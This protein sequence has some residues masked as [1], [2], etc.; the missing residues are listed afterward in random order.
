[1]NDDATHRFTEI[2]VCFAPPREAPSAET[3]V[4][5]FM[6]PSAEAEADARW[7][8]Q[9]ASGRRLVDEVRARARAEYVGL[10]AR[11]GTTAGRD[12]R[13]V[14][15]A[16]GGPGGYSRWWLLQLTEKDCVWDGDPLYVMILRLMAVQ[17]VVER[18]RIGRIRLVG[19][20]RLFAAALG[21]GGMS[22][23]TAIALLRAA[24]VG[25]AARLALAGELLGL[26]WTERRLP[27]RAASP[28][29][30]LLQGYWD[31][32]VR[33][34]G[35]GGLRD[36]YFTDLPSEL[37]R[38]G[39]SVGWLVSCETRQEPWQHGRRRRDVVAEASAHP[40]I[41]LL[42]KYWRPGDIVR[43]A[44]NLRY[45][46]RT[47]RF[48][49]GRGCRTAC[50]V[51]T[52]N[53][54]A[55]VRD[56]LLRAAWGSTCARLELVATAAARAARELQPRLVLTFMELFLRARAIYAGVSAAGVP[57]AAL[58]AAQHGGYSSDKT[59]GVVDP[60]V[61]MRGAP[62]GCAMPSPDGIFVMGDLSRRIWQA[63]GIAAGRVVPTGGLRYQSAQIR[64]E[65]RAVPKARVSVLLA[66]GMNESAEL[67][68][69]DAAVAACAGLPSVRLLWRNHPI[70]EFSRRPAFRRFQ[71][72]IHVTSG[73]LEE[74]LESADLV[75]FTHAGIA[76]EA[77]LRAIP[78]WQWR[79]AGFNTSPF[80][81]VPVIPSFTS[82]AALRR[83]LEQFVRDPARY[84]PTAE[85][86]RRVLHECFGADPAGASSRMAD[87]IE[88]VVAGEAR[89]LA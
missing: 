71:G 56:L 44:L 61:E 23:G 54:H 26:W 19:A 52:S 68:L 75:L 53:V 30:V 28:R 31:W 81:D 74:D 20:P 32:S 1:M 76:E 73:S 8:A 14:R 77:L 29:D 13:T 2:W 16:L 27:R 3:L 46:W 41:T 24:A 6:L 40:E 79:W 5:S 65:R 89:A 47:T 66:C 78:A 50:R 59:L 88:R 57:R 38:R 55:V 22:R 18:H 84:R 12:G 60:D 21:E 45:A 51:G 43:S 82:V 87:A 7:G 4:L 85:V 9:L 48:V 35:E 58:W 72:A 64:A 70:Y 86:Q 67:E 33:P 17:T 34:D 11:L 42:E 83:E 10:V 15:Q 80:L 37:R 39:L 63:T 62:D 49:L 25:V 36:R 69:C